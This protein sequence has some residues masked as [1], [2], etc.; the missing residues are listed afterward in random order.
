MDKV[1]REKSLQVENLKQTLD[2]SNK[3]KQ[4]LE[5]QINEYKIQIKQINTSGQDRDRERDKQVA[6]LNEQIARLRHQLEREVEEKAKAAVTNDLTAD[7][8]K[9]KLDQLQR[10]MRQKNSDIESLRIKLT[11]AIEMQKSLEHEKLQINLDWLRKYNNLE[12]MKAQDGEQF[13][14]DV[15]AERDKALEQIRVLEDKLNHKENVVKALQAADPT[16]SSLSLSLKL[17]S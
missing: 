3:Q 11:E 16:V 14:R 5:Q 17:S 8:L 2:D 1:I 4:Y 12:K 13:T 10:E 9:Q 6:E 7:E 15:M